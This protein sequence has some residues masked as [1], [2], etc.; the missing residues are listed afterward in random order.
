VNENIDMNGKVVMITGANSGI[1]KETAIELA[2][3]GAIIV[4]V[5]RSR[6]RG[7][8]A[9][10]EIKEKANSEKIEL[11]IADLADQSSIRG[12]VERF[13]RKHDKL[14]VLIN[15][16]GVML[17][18]R[19]SSPEGYETTF[20]TNHLGHFLLTNLVLD[21]L[22]VSAPARIVNVSSSVHKFAKLNFDDIDSEHKY[23]GY[24]TYANS[25]LFNI[26]FS[27]DLARR[28]EGT[29]VTVNVLH[30]GVIRTNLGKN[31]NNKLIKL[32]SLI[33]RLFM[34]SPEKGART[35]VYLASS[36]EVENISGEYFV[37]SK[38][39]K[40]SKISYEQTLQNELWEISTNLTIVSHIENINI[41]TIEFLLAEKAAEGT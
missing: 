17:S 18:K 6:E 8:R 14:H 21:M 1:G 10:V 24:R 39:K 5:C 34:K 38:P 27:Y 40:S 36:P 23:R 32:M 33:F 37:N 26:L 12:M 16:A 25:K 9:L 41:E 7:E 31:N 35:T 22:K 11:F 19:T 29:G 4:M 13:K 20:A 30:P 3:M 28:L 15:N 2:K